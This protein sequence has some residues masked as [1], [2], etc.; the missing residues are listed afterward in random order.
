MIKFSFK[1]YRNLSVIGIQLP[2]CAAAGV[3][4]AQSAGD[5]ASSRRHR[6]SVM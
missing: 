4:Q 2:L 3:M 5:S 1:V 6:S